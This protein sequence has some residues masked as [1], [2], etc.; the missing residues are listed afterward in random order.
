[1]NP[2]IEDMENGGY[3]P[4]ASNSL[5]R[6][7]AV[8]RKYEEMLQIDQE[9]SSDDDDSTDDDSSSTGDDMP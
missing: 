5:A 8:I 3:A 7:N 1:M 9:E 2:F 6:L 4:D